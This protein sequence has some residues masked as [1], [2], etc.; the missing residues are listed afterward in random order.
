MK[1]GFRPSMTWLHDWSGLIIGWLLFAIALAGTLSV[2]RA[3]IG[4]W[5]RPEATQGVADPAASG[6]AAVRWLSTHAAQSPSWFIQPADGRSTT[7]Y[8]VWSD[9]VQGFRQKWLDAKT[10]SPGG[11]RDTLGGDFYYRLHFELQ[12]PY[13]WGRILSA[14]AAI[15]MLLAI[16]TGIVA[17]KRFFMDFFTFRPGKGQRS[18][19]DA[20]NLLAVTALPFH[21]MIAFTGALTLA[22]L[23]MPWGGLSAY[24]GDEAALRRDLYPAEVDRPATGVEASL[25]P[26]E[27]MLREAERRFHGG[28]FEIN[29]FNQGDKAAVISVLRAEDAR[30]GIQRG[31]L[32]FDGPT[33]R[34]I[35]AHEEHRPAL[36]TFNFLYALHTA[37]F[38]E[39]LTRW[40]Y[41]L[42]GLAMTAMIGAG[43][44]LW[45]AKRRDRRQG[46]GFALVDRLNVGF[47]G[48]TG[49][50][51]ATFLLAN[52]LLP[53]DL[54]GHVDWEV[55]IVFWGWGALL[56]YA[57]LRR[58]ARA[59]F[60]L[61]TLSTVAGL[62][63][64]LV[65][66]VT[67]TFRP[68]GVGIGVDLVALLLAAGFAY[69]AWR[70]RPA[71]TTIGAGA[72]AL[73]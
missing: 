49:L 11:I 64:P 68:D 15:V 72:K 6:A 65:D 7:S 5:M 28:L 57:A 38:A 43:L 44:L 45:T 27:P 37:R 70:S 13:P 29:V 35:A 53:A 31:V 52:R 32:T 40:L 30:I 12:L 73:A 20:H 69:A 1:P 33:G 62:A 67:G 51:F 66:G 21:I 16:I 22:N 3:E 14:S 2:F 23:V 56:V 63:I 25:A 42:S 71:T 50:A 54:P 61:M 36:R 24:R 10:G 59:W 39:L 18:W 34:L 17:H 58:P 48:G 47:V 46:F 26:I 19:L 41:F 60:E 4:D 55:R 8:A 9:G